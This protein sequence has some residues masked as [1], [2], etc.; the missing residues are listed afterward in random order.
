MKFLEDQNIWCSKQLVSLIEKIQKSASDKQTAHEVFINLAKVFDTVDHTQ[1][2]NKLS[3]YGVTDIVNKW[4]KSYLSH[5]TQYGFHQ[6]FQ[7]KV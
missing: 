6:W 1:M 7:L 2:L 5:H 3:H 4:F